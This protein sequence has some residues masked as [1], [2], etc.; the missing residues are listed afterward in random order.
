VSCHFEHTDNVRAVRVNWKFSLPR[1]HEHSPGA[2]F[3]Y[4][5]I[6]QCSNSPTYPIARGIIS[7]IDFDNVKDQAVSSC[8]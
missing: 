2:K 3:R 5:A 6:L 4:W 8:N 1:V 7:A